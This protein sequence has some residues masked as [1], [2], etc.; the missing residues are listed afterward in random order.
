MSV[1]IQSKAPTKF[2]R[3]DID[4]GGMSVSW[5]PLQHADDFHTRENAES[6]IR[7]LRERYPE[8]EFEIIESN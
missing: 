3:T 8:D 5:V 2:I 6:F 7:R 4:S 1:H